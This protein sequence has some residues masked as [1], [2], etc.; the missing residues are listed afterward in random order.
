MISDIKPLEKWDVSNTINLADLFSGCKNLSDITPIRNWIISKC[1]DISGIFSFCDNLSDITI[2]QKWDVSKFQKL[3]TSWIK[4]VYFL[5]V[6]NY[7]I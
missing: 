6:T 2:L 4:V 7:Q 1:K 3:N 5:I